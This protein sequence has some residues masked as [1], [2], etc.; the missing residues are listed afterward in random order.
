[1]TTLSRMSGGQYAYPVYLTIGNISKTIRRKPTKGASMVIGYLPV[2]SF[3]DVANER[4]RITW[5]GELLHRSLAAIF[6]PLR[7]ASKEGVPMWCAD[8]R[9][10]HVYPILASWIGDWPEQNDVS[11]TIRSGCPICEQKFKGRGS[12]K[13]GQRMRSQEKTLDALREYSRTNN[14]AQ[15]KRCGLKPWWPFWANLPHV[16]FANCITPDLLHQLHKGLF[17]THIMGWVDELMDEAE[18]DARFMSMPRAKDLRHFRRGVNTI[19]QWTGRELKEMMKV[20]L[21]IVATS[22]QLL[23]IDTPDDF[24]E[25]VRTLLDFSYL[26]HA[27]Q[28]TDTELGEMEAALDTFHRLKRV[29]VRLGML[30]SES[31]FDWIPKLH[32]IGHY[33]HSI[34]EFGTPDGYNS[35]TPERLH[36]EF[37]KKG[38]Q[39]SNRRD[40][41]PQI[42]TFVQRREAIKIH[43]MLLNDLHGEKE[44]QGDGWGH[45]IDM[46]GGDANDE[47]EDE[48][49]DDEDDEYDDVVDGHEDEA[50]E[51]EAPDELS[52]IAYPRPA[53]SIALSPTR[54]KLSGNVLI[55]DYGASDL[56]PALRKFLAPK[57]RAL[58]ER[59]SVQP[60]DIF[61]VWHKISLHHLP[62][63]FA[64]GEPL[65]RDV[66]RAQ[67]PVY[68]GCGRLQRPGFFDTALFLNDPTRSGIHRRCIV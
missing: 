22:S 6:D 59:I 34:R 47:D 2:D 23:G 24:V 42:I 50:D 43:R 41:I 10:R 60:S 28:L 16:H 39:A 57:A 63:P 52:D 27:A 49:E 35:E 66:I 56:I 17:K 61:N 36:I 37:A 65:H 51:D 1:M 55:K 26:A 15:L 68:D 11:C 20:F 64:L 67:A 12:G 30:D 5:K 7:T 62:L 58:Q 38:W 33:G 14:M 40:P 19:S 25:M 31:R 4:L 29:V 8:G 46:V 3:K 54:A 18:M 53:R 45:G 13:R 21:P 48:D 9:L 32:M 44:G